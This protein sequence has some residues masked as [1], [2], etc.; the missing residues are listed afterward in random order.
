MFEQAANISPKEIKAYFYLLQ[1]QPVASLSLY[2]AEDASTRE[3]R[4][5]RS[6]M[7]DEDFL[8]HAFFSLENTAVWINPAAFQAFMIDNQDSFAHHR[9]RSSD[10][11]PFSSRALSR[12]DSSTHR[13]VS[14]ASSR[15]SFVPSSRA[16]SP[17]SWAASDTGP[18]PPSAMS[19]AF[20]D[21]DNND[22]QDLNTAHL[23]PSLRSP[24][25]EVS[26]TTMERP[27]SPPLPNSGNIVLPE[28]V[29]IR[30]G[31]GKGKAKAKQDSRINIT[32]ELKVNE[33]V[34]LSILPSTFPVPHHPTALRIDLSKVEGHLTNASGKRST[35]DAYIRSEV[36]TRT[37]G[38]AHR[39]VSRVM[40]RCLASTPTR[41][42]VSKVVVAICIATEL[43]PVNTSMMQSSRAA[44]GMRE[45]WDHELEANQTEAALPLGVLARFYARVV[46]SK[47]KIKC[48][49][50]PILFKLQDAMKYGK[51]LCVGCSNC[52]IQEKLLHRY[53]FIPPNVYENTFEY[54]FHNNGAFHLAVPVP[55][56]KAAFSL[57][58]LALHYLIMTWDWASSR[59]VLNL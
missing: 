16:S 31:K 12:A 52:S 29:P 21:L 28:P 4:A 54:V 32:R 36:R 34:N 30:K 11:T 9:H 10:S 49:G 14:R 27:V 17:V 58:I 37:P 35:L 7:V 22:L 56:M 6:C 18:R 40:L 53:E 46:N 50:V 39:G 42:R 43:K 1:D 25:V 45:L 13:S 57:S 59:R 48:D 23:P 20:N 15:A 44:S 5:Y 47:C 24:S 19:D 51:H 8:G 55:S 38:K 2:N 3:L 41:P 26:I 33:I